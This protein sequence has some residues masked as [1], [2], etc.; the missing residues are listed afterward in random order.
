MPAGE[1][2]DCIRSDSQNEAT[3]ANERALAFLVQASTALSST[4]DRFE[5][6]R[7]IA[8]LVIPYLADWCVVDIVHEGRIVR[9][10][11]AAS[12]AAK[13][14]ALREIFRRQRNRR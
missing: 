9:Q 3:A 7:R 10:E 14:A 6:T 11:V 5:V 12:T 8:E 4:L 1:H 13:Q 2:P